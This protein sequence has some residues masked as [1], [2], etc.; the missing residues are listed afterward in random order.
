MRF[1][2]QLRRCAVGQRIHVVATFQFSGGA[3]DNR[4]ADNLTGLAGLRQILHQRAHRPTPGEADD[5][6]RLQQPVDQLRAMQ[7]DKI[8]LILLQQ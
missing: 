3:A 8:E 6:A 4:H 2:F 5:I 7:A 1:R